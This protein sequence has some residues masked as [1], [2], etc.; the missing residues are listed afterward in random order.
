MCVFVC[1]YSYIT[2]TQSTSVQLLF[3][4]LSHSGSYLIVKELQITTENYYK[5]NLN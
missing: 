1:V 2:F 4:L 3:H 5:T